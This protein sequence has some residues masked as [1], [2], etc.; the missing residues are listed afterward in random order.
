MSEDPRAQIGSL[1][2]KARARLGLS[3]DTLALRVQDA[4]LPISA[5]KIEAIERGTHLPNTQSAAVL[6]RVLGID[7]GGFVLPEP[8]TLVP[9]PP[10]APGPALQ[11][12]E[13]KPERAHKAA[14]PKRPKNHTKLSEGPSDRSIR[15]IRIGEYPRVTLYLD[16]E[17]KAL[18]DAASSV[19]GVAAYQI[20]TLA[21]RD[22][23]KT[24]SPPDRELI[25][26]LALATKAR[27]GKS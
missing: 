3:R 8:K 6:A 27:R 9:S 2:A 5:S 24:L 1:V 14:R 17:T 11:P 18:L 22:H 20:L 19:L 12:L 21:F 16:P 10:S 15:P 4:G 23:L 25:E 26:R 13:V 7:L